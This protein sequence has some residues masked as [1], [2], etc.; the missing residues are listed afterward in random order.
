MEDTNPI[1]SQPQ[2][3]NNEQDDPLLKRKMHIF[4]KFFWELKGR[5]MRENDNWKI[6][7]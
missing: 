7:F 4:V 2:P 5:T 6:H 1:E 3:L